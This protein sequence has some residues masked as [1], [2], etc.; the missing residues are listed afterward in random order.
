MTFPA[1]V[2]TNMRLLLEDTDISPSGDIH[3]AAKRWL[4]KFAVKK[5]LAE[6]LN[7]LLPLAILSNTHFMLCHWESGD[8][9]I[10]I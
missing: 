7:L 3:S 10:F 4:V 9:V 6:K 2:E 5:N 8:Q 1:F